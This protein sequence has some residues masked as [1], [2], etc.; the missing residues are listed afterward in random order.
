MIKGVRLSNERLEYL[1]DAVLSSAIADYL[2]KKFPYK[3][4]GFLTEM[5]SKIVNRA[6]LNKLS[7][8]LGLDRFLESENDSKNLCKSINGDAFEALIGAMYLD[9]GYNFT[10]RIIIK[11]II[12]LHLDIDEIEKLENNYKSKL[13]EWSQKEKR[14]RIQCDR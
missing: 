6:Q 13:I 11:R 9:R 12:N 7:K 14:D 3:D 10:R 4:E 5:R 1:G 2:F 8:K